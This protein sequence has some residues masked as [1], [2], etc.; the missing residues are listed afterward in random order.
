MQF[1]IVTSMHLSARG[2]HQRHQEEAQQSP[3]DLEGNDR[4]LENGAGRW[5]GMRIGKPSEL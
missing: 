1:M 5:G 3:E 4:H 2:G